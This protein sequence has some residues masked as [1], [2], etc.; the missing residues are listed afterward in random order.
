MWTS[1][2]VPTTTLCLSEALHPRFLMALLSDWGGGEFYD[3]SN[4]GNPRHWFSFKIHRRQ[5]ENKMSVPYWKF[6]DLLGFASFSWFRLDFR[7]PGP[8]TVAS[9][10]FYMPPLGGNKR[11]RFGLPSNKSFVG[12][13][14]RVHKKCNTFRLSSGWSYV[15][16]SV[17]WSY[18]RILKRKHAISR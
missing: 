2:T 10:R 12:S 9:K 8:K 16:L 4:R 7:R 6:D 1:R 14:N 17:R 3:S 13:A 5:H 18:V 15:T 11:K